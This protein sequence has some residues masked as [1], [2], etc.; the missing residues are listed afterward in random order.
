MIAPQI[1]IHLKPF[2]KLPMRLNDPAPEWETQTVRADSI[3]FRKGIMR[4]R[5]KDTNKK[6]KRAF[7]D[8]GAADV[9]II[10]RGCPKW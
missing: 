6:W 2:P 8:I 1:K 9:F 4:F 5:Y 7:C 3:D 10:D